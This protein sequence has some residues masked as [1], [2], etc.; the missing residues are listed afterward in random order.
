M[1]KIMLFLVILGHNCNRISPYICKYACCSGGEGMSVRVE[2]KILVFTVARKSFST[3][4]RRNTCEN[5]PKLRVWRSYKRKNFWNKET[6][7]VKISDTRDFDR[8]FCYNISFP[9]IAEVTFVSAK[10]SRN[11]LFICLRQE[12]TRAAAQ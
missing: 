3:F 1:K 6:I 10:V 8:F 11:Y 5:I 7:F 12:Q 4:S 9:K 2:T